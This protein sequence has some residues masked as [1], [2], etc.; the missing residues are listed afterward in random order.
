MSMPND[1]VKTATEYEFQQ[2]LEG[3]K[4]Q[5]EHPFEIIDGKL[6]LAGVEIIS[7]RK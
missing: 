7:N 2:R 5:Q 4:V 3:P 1:N 6:L